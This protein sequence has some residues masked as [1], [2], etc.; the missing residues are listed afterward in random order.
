M[1]E[2]KALNDFIEL[3]K[4]VAA[5]V[6]NGVVIL[7]AGKNTEARKI[8]SKSMNAKVEGSKLLFTNEKDTKK[9]RKL[10]GTLKAHLKNM[11]KGVTQGHVY[12]LKI[13][14]GHFPMSVAVAKDELV[15]KNYLGEK[16]PRTLKLNQRTKVKVE[17]DHIIVESSSKELAGQTAAAIETLTKRANYDRRIFQDGIYIINKDGEEV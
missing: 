11:I 17:G 1:K 4:E 3:P 7:T 9:E 12:Q 16:V 13:C 10:M 8:G 5:K 2:R 14:S 15:V 6:E